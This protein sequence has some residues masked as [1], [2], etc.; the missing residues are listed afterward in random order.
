LISV[1]VAIRAYKVQ[2]SSAALLSLMNM[3]KPTLLT[4][5]DFTLTKNASV[6]PM[7]ISDAQEIPELFSYLNLVGK[8]YLN[9]SITINCKF[10]PKRP[11]ISA[12]SDRCPPKAGRPW[13]DKLNQAVGL[14]RN[15]ALL[16]APVR[17]IL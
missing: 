11:A 10:R 8:L 2:T 15:L 14:V 3:R 7:A 12:E 5:V 6:M 17:A 9:K 1:F 4:E 13:A 16:E